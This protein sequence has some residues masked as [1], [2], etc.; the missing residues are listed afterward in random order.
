MLVCVVCTCVC[1]CVRVHVSVLMWACACARPC[2]SFRAFRGCLQAIQHEGT[3]A[4]LTDNNPATIQFEDPLNYS[5]TYKVK[6]THVH[7]RTHTH[8][9]PPL[10]T[11]P[12]A[13]FSIL[14]VHS[15]FQAAGIDFISIANNHQYDFGL[16]G[17]KRT[18][19]C[20]HS[21]PS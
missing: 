4:E 18:P 5:A 7:T 10:L 14:A 8:R 11:P 13:L 9:S 19:A 20:S 21:S 6:N 16:Q 2:F 17:L 3:L 15:T 1:V 12:L